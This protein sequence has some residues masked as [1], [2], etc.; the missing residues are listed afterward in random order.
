MQ[1]R[2][3]QITRQNGGKTEAILRSFA[4]PREL[5][6]YIEK[7]P[8]KPWFEAVAHSQSDD[9][10][11]ANFSGSKTWAEADRM[12]S[13]GCP[14]IAQRIA[15]VVCGAK[16]VERRTQIERSVAGFAPCVPSWLNGDPRSMFTSKKVT[17]QARKIDLYI[18]VTASCQYTAAQIEEGL[19]EVLSMIQ[20]LEKSGY[21]VAITMIASF[22]AETKR[23]R[24]GR[25][26]EHRV[27]AYTMPIKRAEERLSVLRLSYVCCHPSMLRRHC[28]ALLERD[29]D[30]NEK[31]YI[32]TYGFVPGLQDV[33][34]ILDVTKP[35]AVVIPGIFR[36]RKEREQVAQKIGIPLTKLQSN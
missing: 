33:Q 24:G 25:A 11:A 10:C 30:T 23:C 21:R 3:T 4:G 18:S 34:K 22:A 29:P 7:T 2:K 8:V 13:A 31:D 1:T 6:E 15:A 19:C 12:F 9:R 36:D 32:K 14:E 16:P 20:G 17:K 5:S 28:F 27:I 26:A 35:G